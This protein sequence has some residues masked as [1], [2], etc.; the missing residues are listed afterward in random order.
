VAA[1]HGR[2]GDTGLVYGL[3]IPPGFEHDFA[4][5]PRLLWALV[6]PTDLGLA[7]IFHDRLYRAGGQVTTW[8]WTDAPPSDASGAPDPRGTWEA[9]LTPWRRDQTDALFARIM[10]E[11]GVVRW[12][13]RAAYHAVQ[14]FGE[15]HWRSPTS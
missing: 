14:V 6:A 1:A 15:P 8:A 13:R 7:S 10:R 5:V 12:R 11:Q 2:T 9:R 3:V 4:S